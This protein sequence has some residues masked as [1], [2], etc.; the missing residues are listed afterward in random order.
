MNNPNDIGKAVKSLLGSSEK[1]LELTD[2]RIYPII[3]LGQE[4][5][6]I[7]YLKESVQPAPTKDNVSYY[8][9]NV[10]VTTIAQS[11]SDMV[12]LSCAVIGALNGFNGDVDGIRI[13]SIYFVLAK[14]SFDE[15][16]Y[17]QDVH[18]EIKILTNN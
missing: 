14:D 8:K 5:P 2:G 16:A 9:A 7:V 17:M 3:A 6:C 12:E 13:K 1:V 10:V 18:F 4:T 15:G 11:Y